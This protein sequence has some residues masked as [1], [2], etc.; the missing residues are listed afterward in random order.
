LGARGDAD[1]EMMVAV[2]GVA[3]GAV[4]IKGSLGPLR[5]GSAVKFTGLPSPQPSPASGRG[6][7]SAAPRP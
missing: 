6:S 2:T 3:P 1:G 5:E 4:V 7:D